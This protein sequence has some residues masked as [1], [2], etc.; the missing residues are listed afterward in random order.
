MPWP[1]AVASAMVASMSDVALAWSPRRD[2]SIIAVNGAARL[3]V[4]SL[5]AS[6]SATRE[7]AAAKSPL[8]VTAVPS[9]PSRIGS[10]SSAPRS[11]ATWIC[12]ASIVC[13]A[14]SSHSALAAA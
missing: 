4:A 3:P 9:A 8:Q 6:A 11:R 12:R 5:T 2:A 13:Q 1:S 7:A 10:R 14:S